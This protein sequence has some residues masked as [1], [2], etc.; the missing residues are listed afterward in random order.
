MG[1]R[2]S[3]H[4]CLDCTAGDEHDEFDSADR[5]H[6]RP[7]DELQLEQIE[8][9]RDAWAEAGWERTPQVS[10]SR[11]VIPL[12]DEQDRAYFGER[13]GDDQVGHLDG[14]LARF[15][16]SYVGTPDVLAEELAKDVAVQAADSLLLTV[17]NQLGVDYN[18]RLLSALADHV[19]PAIG[20]KPRP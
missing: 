12:L 8:I 13:S 10:V 16:K 4:G 20:W 19:L 17:P 15:G 9:F 18:T 7:F 2:Q 6:R 11:S 14:G 5:R 3:V 1:I